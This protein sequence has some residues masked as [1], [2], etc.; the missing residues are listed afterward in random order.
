MK[1]IILVII[2]VL[3]NGAFINAQA[4]RG[5]IKRTSK[6]FSV[7]E[8]GLKK[9][10]SNEDSNKL[11]NQGFLTV[12]IC[13]DTAVSL[14]YKSI[15]RNIL[16][17]KSIQ[18]GKQVYLKSNSKGYY[19][20]FK[21]PTNL[22]AELQAKDWKKA[23]G[24]P[25]KDGFQLVAKHKKLPTFEFYVTIDTSEKYLNQMELK[26]IFPSVFHPFGKK[27]QAGMSNGDL[28]E[29]NWNEFILNED[30][31]CKAFFDDFFIE[32]SEKFDWDKEINTSATHTNIVPISNRKNLAPGEFQDVNGEPAFLD[33]L[34]GK[35]VYLDFWASWCSPCR[36]EMPYTEKIRDQY[37]NKGLEV[38]SITIDQI[39]A[40]PKWKATIDKLDMDWHNWYLEY[41][42]DSS[43]A[44]GIQLSGIPRYLLL[45]PAGRIV[46]D[47]A[48]RPSDPKLIEL[49]DK[50]LSEDKN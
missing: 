45:D 50:V 8:N 42:K 19:Y 12:H 39:S 20:P 3:I 29:I 48:P 15:N 27:I 41:G 32:E 6:V 26:G 34:H 17:G 13:G 43:L 49:L 9:G 16:K 22:M 33:E 37:Q 46:N 36:A 18:I 4:F 28:Y 11:K 5:T 2:L 14:R 47:N 25:K 38:V 40:I 1:K 21:G 23:K 44:K 35:Y 30:L 10:I 31:V 24:Q 7:Q